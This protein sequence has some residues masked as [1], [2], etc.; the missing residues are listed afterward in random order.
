MW[1]S[2]STGSTGESEK[3]TSVS[4]RERPVA[5]SDA[6]LSYARLESWMKGYLEAWQSNFPADIEALFT[7]DALYYTAPFRDP[8]R[9]RDAIVAG[10]LGR[11]DEPGKWEFEWD[12]I[13]LSSNI[14]FV[15][16][17]TKYFDGPSYSNLWV[18]PAGR[19]RPLLRIRRVVD[20]AVL[21]PD[22][23]S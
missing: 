8:W 17:E 5:A 16:G 6:D 1:L 11:K 14:A 18:I 9:G 2:E 23:M 22:Q 20:G 10:W 12:P 19:R 3:T 13:L 15:Q 4:W 7:E 21:E